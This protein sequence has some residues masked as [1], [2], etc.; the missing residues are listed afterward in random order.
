MAAE[1]GHM[2]VAVDGRVCGCGHRGCLEAYASKA[3][4][5][6]RFKTELRVGNRR[7]ILRQESGDLANVR[8]GVLRRGYLE[9]DRVIRE[10]VDEAARYLGI[11]IANIITVL[12]PD[13]VVLGGGVMEALG[14]KLL[15]IV[16]QAAREHTFPPPSFRDTRIVLSELGDDAVAL[17]AVAYAR[18][19]VAQ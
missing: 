4:M 5:G 17:G 6:R 13:R 10:G 3:G 16:R 15:P 1:L 18:A 9:G 19:G 8:S 7:S 12:G 14:R 11:G 2:V